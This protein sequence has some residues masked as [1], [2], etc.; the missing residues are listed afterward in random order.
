MKYLQF[1]LL[2]FLVIIIAS[3]DNLFEFSVYDADV[4]QEQQNTTNK[5]LDL[6]KEIQVQSDTFKF[7][8]LTDAHWFYDN[9]VTVVDDINKK[10]EILFVIFG[11]DITEQAILKEYTTFYDIM[12]KLNK[13][14]FTVIGNHDYNTNGGLIYSRMFG[15]YNYSFEFN[16]NKFILFDNV[17]W[18]SEKLPDFNWLS[19]ELQNN[20]AYNQVFSIAHIP[21]NGDQFTEEMKKTY[22]GLMEDN[23]VPLSIHGH[24]HSFSFLEGDVSYLTL[25]SLKDTAYGII[26]VENKSFNQELIEL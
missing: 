23:N 2:F 6:L 15:A 18:E 20:A 1:S 16:N 4:K 7:A 21:P 22:E 26:T 13:P 14:Y 5:N 19:N 24:R 11:G 25:P 17:V 3:C 9:L 10:D 8:F 12:S